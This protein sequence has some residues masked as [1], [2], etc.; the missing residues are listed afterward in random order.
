MKLTTP[1]CRG[2]ET[3]TMQSRITSRL[4][5]L[6]APIRRFRTNLEVTFTYLAFRWR[7]RFLIKR[8]IHIPRSTVPQTPH[9]EKGI[10]ASG[11][12]VGMSGDQGFLYSG[13][14]L[15]TISFENS[16]QTFAHGI[17]ASGEI[18]GWYNDRSSDHGFLL[19]SGSYT[20][21]D[22]PGAYN[23][24]AEGINASGQIVG[25]YQTQEG[26][27]YFNHG[28]IYS[29][30][31]YTI[32][33]NPAAP[34]SPS[35][36]VSGIAVLD[37]NARGQIV[38]YYN[39]STGF[40]HGFVY[41]GGTFTTLDNPLGVGGTSLTGINDAGEIVGLYGD[42]IGTHGFL[43]SGGT[44][45]TI[46]YPTSPGNTRVYDISNS[47]QIVGYYGD[48]HTIH[49]FLATPTNA[50]QKLSESADDGTGNGRPHAEGVAAPMDV[51][52]LGMH[53]SDDFYFFDGAP[54]VQRR[55]LWRG[56]FTLSAAAVV[57]WR[58][59]FRQRN[60]ASAHGRQRLG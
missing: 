21:I 47:G 18:V 41:S 11:E 50:H 44:F 52:I 39:D 43:Y 1:L 23:T 59:R 26:G 46:D 60:V 16:L 42:D 40:F 24:F 35:A 55:L 25:Y 53:A 13:G 8:P 34:S 9:L 10:N 5:R 14:E 12:I 2:V 27:G 36:S 30:G 33:E 56:P 20:T 15:T 17:N 45:T 58:S 4:Q 3:T 22:V 48:S 7:Q 57:H 37:I 32:L 38:G 28:F 51:N 29:G 31:S 54:T 6:P 19:S 49:G